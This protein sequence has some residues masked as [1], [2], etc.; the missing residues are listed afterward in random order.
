MTTSNS[1]ITHFSRP[2]KLSL[3]IGLVALVTSMIGLL[4]SGPT[5]FF[6]SYLFAFLFWLGISLGSMAL[7]FLHF[8]VGSRWGLT[9]RRVAEAA[10]SSIWIMA[11]LFVPLLFAINIL[12]PWTDPAAVAEG[13]A[14]H[15]LE[16]KTFYLNVPFFL[17]R[18]VIYFVAWILLSILANRWSARLSKALPED[19]PIRG[20]LQGIGAIGLIVYAITMTFASIDW[21]MSL[22]PLWTS[23]IFG[24]ITMV[25]QMLTALAFALLALNLLPGLSL[26]RQW[27]YKQTPLSFKDLGSFLLVFI[28]GWSYLVYFQFLI[29]WGGNIPREVAWYIARTD[30]GWSLLVIFI[31]VFQFLL[32][33]LILLSSRARHNLRIL[34]ILGALLL[35]TNLVYLFWQVKPAFFP[36]Q[37]AI[38]WL[39]LVLPI[40]VGGL[41]IA[42][43]LYYLARRPALTTGERLALRLAEEPKNGNA[44]SQHQG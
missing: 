3:G 8:S 43:F 27:N 33:F 22:E 23:T 5:Q 41:W 25:G 24:M 32:P 38:S 21:I 2:M 17:V 36:G 13:E 28:L 34:S 37:F 16:A 11:V 15:M 14:L 4:V 10:S 18:A 42:G 44:V 20:R 6:Q 29:M 19:Q 40:A 30:G 26:G 1:A 12:F 31:A 35:F 9:I 7:L 39:D